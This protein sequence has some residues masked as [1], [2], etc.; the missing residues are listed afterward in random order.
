V[1]ALDSSK[2]Q[3]EAMGR[4]DRNTHKWYKS[5]HFRTT[6]MGQR[7]KSHHQIVAMKHCRC[8][9]WYG[10]RGCDIGLRLV[11]PVAL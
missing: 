11:G 9:F 10:L 2:D 3:V 4:R 6:V 7:Q 8:G 1:A 5:R